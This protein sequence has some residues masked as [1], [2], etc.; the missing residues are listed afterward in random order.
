MMSS[1]QLP[2][3]KP[4]ARILRFRRGQPPVRPHPDG[5]A[6]GLEKYERDDQPDD[7]QHRMFV[8]IAAFAVLVLLVAGGYWLADTMARMR[9]DQ[10]CVLSGRRNCSPVPQDIQQN[11]R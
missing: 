2:P 7:Y 3:D 4:G 6:P 10:D 1:G 11:R 8:N 9:K 5:P